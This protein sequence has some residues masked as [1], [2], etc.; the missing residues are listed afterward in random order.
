MPSEA[1]SLSD[2]TMTRW[3]AAAKP[4]PSGD[5]A[6]VGRPAEASSPLAAVLLR[7]R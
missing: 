3:S 4:P 5:H 6:G 7:V 1:C 2:F